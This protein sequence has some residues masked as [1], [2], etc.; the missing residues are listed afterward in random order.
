M[1]CGG[2]SVTQGSDL[3][4]GLHRQQAALPHLGLVAHGVVG[5]LAQDGV[6]GVQEGSVDEVGDPVVK[7]ACHL[8]GH[9]PPGQV[10]VAHSL[11]QQRLHLVHLCPAHACCLVGCERQEQ[12]GDAPGVNDG[13]QVVE[14]GAVEGGRAGD[15]VWHEAL[16]S[17]ADQLLLRRV[18]HEAAL[19][20]QAGV[21]HRLAHALD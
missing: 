4:C 7:E 19:P 2:G 1:R 16:G 11:L 17:M 6:V 5:D 21:E 3:I 13:Q 15:C 8:H 12:G 14:S 18:R 10:V 9:V 20:L